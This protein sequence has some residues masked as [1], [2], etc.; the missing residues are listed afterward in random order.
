M[1]RKMGFG[2]DYI[3][4]S[5][6]HS[7]IRFIKKWYGLALVSLSVV[8]LF[9]TLMR[10]KFVFPLP[11]FKQAYLLHAHSHFAF[12]GWISQF[13]YTGFALLLFSFLKKSQTKKYQL[14][15]LLNLISAYG[16]LIAFTVQGYKAIS[17]TFSTLS[18]LVSI[19][20]AFQFIRDLKYLPS[21][22]PSKPWC[23]AGLLFNVFS[24]I[25]PFTIGYMMATDIITQK[26]L[27]I[28]IYYFL[29]FQY[30]GWFFFGSIALIVKTLPKMLIRIKTYFW[31][32]LITCVISYLLSLLWLELPEW[33]FGSA[34]VAAILQLMVWFVLMLRFIPILRKQP[35]IIF[36]AWIR[37]LLYLAA[38]AFSL[39]FIMQA[40]SLLPSLAHLVF[41]FRPVVI[42]YLHLV[43]LGGYSLF[44]IAYLFAHNYIPNHKVAKISAFVFLSGIILNELFLGLQG[45]MEGILFHRLPRIN[46]LLLVAAVIL[47]IGSV[48]LVYSNFK[49]NKKNR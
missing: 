44:F 29:H 20:F 22:H 26:Y 36:P 35:K 42:G 30:N 28:A 21:N 24:S 49:R 7:Q 48:G 41:G 10:Y 43:L 8:A 11:F 46:E 13:L 40:L 1:K 25:G 47:L 37:S 45:I 12:T 33:L 2:K 6:N 39:K 19:A 5:A 23:I 32:F 14:L 17:I 16:M 31:I 4:R 9:G 18:I 3:I 27:D 15:L 38:A 34:A